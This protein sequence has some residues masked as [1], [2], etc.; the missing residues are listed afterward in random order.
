M[1]RDEG[2][3]RR[4]ARRAALEALYAADVA[5]LDAGEVLTR[6]A[7]VEGGAGSPDP[8][9]RRLVDGVCANREELDRR[10][11][12]VAEHWRLDRMPPV[13]R[14]LLRIALY[15][16]DACDDIPVGATINE[17]VELARCFSTTES[18]RFVN[19][20]LGRLAQSA[21]SGS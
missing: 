20:L 14:A 16:I 13:D 19:G 21:P 6:E 12:E 3:R 17:A 18:G 7:E 8:F 11:G 1:S 9:A 15:E 2:R 5:G 4:R 10:I